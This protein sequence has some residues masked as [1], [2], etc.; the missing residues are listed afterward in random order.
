MVRAHAALHL[1]EERLVEVKDRLSPMVVQD[2]T[3]AVAELREE[4][5]R[6]TDPT[7][8][9][10]IVASADQFRRELQEPTV[11]ASSDGV[12]ALDRARRAFQATQREVR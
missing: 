7:R 12:D 1:L 3:Q 10:D 2:V 11:A 8:L 6:T 5:Q 9:L 4:L